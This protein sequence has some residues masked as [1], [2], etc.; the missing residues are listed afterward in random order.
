MYYLTHT[1]HGSCEYCV[2]IDGERQ[3]FA[4]GFAG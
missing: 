2:T 1:E 3:R 4:K